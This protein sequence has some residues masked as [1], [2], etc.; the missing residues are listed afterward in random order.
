MGA[1]MKI[2]GSQTVRELITLGDLLEPMRNA[3]VGFTTGTVF[4]HPRVTAE[5]T[6]TDRVLIM[7]AATAD[8]MG[9]KIITM[10]QRAVEHALP[11]IQGLI[12]LIDPTHGQPVAIV[13]GTVITELRTAAVS[14]LATDTLARDDATTLAI[15]GAGVQA[16]AHLTALQSI[17]DWT[18][19]RIHSRTVSK[20][21]ALYTWARTHGLPATLCHSPTDAVS[22]A[23]VICTATSSCQPVLS[24][25]DVIPH[26]VHI[27]AV[28][29]FGPTCRELPTDLVTRCTLFADSQDSVSR[30]AGDILVPIAEGH[31]SDLSLTEIG[32]VFAGAHPGRTTP[33]ENTL[34]KSL[35][36]PI[37]DVV[38]C[39][40]VYQ[41][42][43]QADAG[44]NV[45]F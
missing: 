35:G 42:A 3:L 6:P 16:R 24:T 28:G 38:A 25:D 33:D 5:P 34:F 22:G 11:S 18:T 30:E 13:D 15:L 20:A 4:Q 37:E 1:G 31:L 7:P 29:A 9:I 44:V 27:T 36:L 23:D 12:I 2:I 32:S 43:V 39:N 14:A 40:L 10:Y 45:E 41:R 17:R 8:S 19:I 26:G 21:D